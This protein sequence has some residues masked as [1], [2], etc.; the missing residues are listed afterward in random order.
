MKNREKLPE[1]IDR[2]NRNELQGKE[3]EEFLEMMKEDPGLRQEVQLDK[4]LNEMI[5]EKDIVELRRKL[6]RNRIPK[7]DDRINLPVILMAAAVI[8]LICLTVFAYFQ[9]RIDVEPER[10]SD[11]TYY[12]A[13]TLLFNDTM[14][15]EEELIKGEQSGID[16][17]K[18]MIEK[19]NPSNKDINSLA[20]NYK[21]YLPYEGLIGEISRSAGFRLINPSGIISVKKGTGLSFKWESGLKNITMIIS[22]NKG[23]SV[24]RS[25]P[26]TEGKVTYSTSE[27]RPGLFYVRFISNNELVFIT[28]FILK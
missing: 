12:P 27:L 7:R 14:Q 15:K 28:K 17:S 11:Y 20:G 18:A 19:G 9:L 1:W 24:Y 25:N 21:P 16:K 26:I 13:D 8:I 5:R 23:K 2:Y 3:L 10:K 6:I 22:D 4:E